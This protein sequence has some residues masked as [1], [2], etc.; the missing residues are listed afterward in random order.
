MLTQ[1]AVFSLAVLAQGLRY[2]RISTP[3]QRQQTKWLFLG[4]VLIFVG[5]LLF[6]LPRLP[7]AAAHAIKRAM[8]KQPGERFTSAG[9]FVAALNPELQNSSSQESSI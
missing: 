7:S 4:I 8:A 5:Y 2:F 1:V 9:E 6:V 3:I